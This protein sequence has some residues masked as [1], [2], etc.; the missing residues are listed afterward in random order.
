MKTSQHPAPWLETVFQVTGFER[1]QFVS[2]L[3]ATLPQEETFRLDRLNF[4]TDG[5]RV[6]GSLT[7]RTQNGRQ[8]D[9]ITQRL[10]AVSGVVSVLQKR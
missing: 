4:E 6:C 8:L 10:R 1:I 3:V 2:D 7:I 5:V 9:G